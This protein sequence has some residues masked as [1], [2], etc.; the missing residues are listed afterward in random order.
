[1][2][3]HTYS[4]LW[5]VDNLD[6][7]IEL[8]VT[9]CFSC[10][11]LANTRS[12]PFWP[13]SEWTSLYLSRITRSCCWRLYSVRQWPQVIHQLCTTTSLVHD[14]LAVHQLPLNRQKSLN[15]SVSGKSISSDFRLHLADNCVCGRPIS[16]D[17]TSWSS[18]GCYTMCLGINYRIYVYTTGIL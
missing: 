8:I 11:L 16:V 2:Y 5:T 17:R 3:P 14:I 10:P 1:M 9:N 6:C 15:I 4:T 7:H 12:Q 13:S 18:C